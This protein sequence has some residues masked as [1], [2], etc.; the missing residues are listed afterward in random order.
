MKTGKAIDII[1]QDKS[2]VFK[3]G[4]NLELKY[5]NDLER[6]VVYSIVNNTNDSPLDSIHL[7]QDW[8]LVEKTISFRELIEFPYDN[9]YL[10]FDESLPIKNLSNSMPLDELFTAIGSN[11][12]VEDI[13][14]IIEHGRFE[15]DY[16]Q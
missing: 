6:I 16:N 11:F 9:I 10:R 4:E 13:C 12:I 7:N 3:S 15:V 14:D 5:D 8:F 2:R 1:N